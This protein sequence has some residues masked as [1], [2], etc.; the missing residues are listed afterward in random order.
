MALVTVAVLAYVTASTVAEV[1]TGRGSLVDLF[2]HH[3]AHGGWGDIVKV[4]A[5]VLGIFGATIAAVLAARRQHTAETQQRHDIAKARDE[6]A[7]ALYAAAAT[8]LGSDNAPTRIAGM[9][10]L[11]RLGCDHPEMRQVVVD[12]WCAYLRTP[13]TERYFDHDRVGER[14]ERQ[15]RFTAQSLLLRHLQYMPWWDGRD[16]ALYWDQALTIDL[17]GA[18][19]HD[20]G[21]SNLRIRGPASFTGAVFE[22][23]TFIDG[24]GGCMAFESDLYFRGAIFKGDAA[25]QGE[26]NQHVSF[27]GTVFEGVV[28]FQHAHFTVVDFSE[29]MFK[30]S[31]WFA[32]GCTFHGRDVPPDGPFG[33]RGARY[34]A[35]LHGPGVVDR[36][37]DKDDGTLFP[38]HNGEPGGIAAEA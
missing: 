17:R 18:H 29:A 15:V 34:F 3:V 24:T 25:F 26:F 10:S 2:S 14:E 13:S 8:Q 36:V 37:G 4:T 30:G 33:F 28:D 38:I 6:R 19:L 32:G 35:D 1:Q 22:G 7:S 21:D 9:Y 31:T 27:A 23:E 20:F 16:H 11:E 5:T 12:L